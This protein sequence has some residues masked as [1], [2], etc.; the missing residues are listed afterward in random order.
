MMH[1]LSV[2]DKS[3]PSALEVTFHR[4]TIYS[5]PHPF[6][7]HCFPFK[8]SFMQIGCDYMEKKRSFTASGFLSLWLYSGAMRH[9]H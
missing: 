7:T 4:L 9:I 2:R 6:F 1:A 3:L 5:I 8:Y